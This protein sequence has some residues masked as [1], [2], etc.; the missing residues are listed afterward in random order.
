MSAPSIL[1]LAPA[2]LGHDGV[3][4]VS[5]TAWRELARATPTRALSLH[6]ISGALSGQGITGEEARGSRARFAARILAQA[7]VGCPGIVLAMHAHLAP[8]ALPLRT[9]GARLIVFLH[10]IEAWTRLRGVRRLALASADLLVANS[11]HTLRRFHEANPSLVTVPA[12]ICP[13]GIAAP[14][15]RLRARLA[16]DDG[17]A[18]LIVGRL[19]PDERYKGHDLLLEIW[20]RVLRCVPD[21]RLIVVGDG[22]DRPRLQARAGALG[23]AGRMSFVGRAAPDVLSGLYEDSAFFA[24]PSQ[25]EGFGLVYLEAMAFG[26]ACVGG[27][28]AAEEVIEHE[29]TGLIVDP[30]DR[31]AVTGALV[32]LFL[33]PGLR[34]RLGDAGRARQ[35]RHFTAAAFGQRLRALLGLEGTAVC[36]G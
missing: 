2:L 14:P 17:P 3:S 21:A 16:P 32:R 6:D 15:P 12:A 26:R 5:L 13:L 33:D 30:A 35:Q 25:G 11:R 31:D 8:A 9:R 29:R 36:A 34:Q 27:R 1:L 24:L 18:A 20:P 4:G 28:G 10:G 7:I 19:H 23:V 22:E